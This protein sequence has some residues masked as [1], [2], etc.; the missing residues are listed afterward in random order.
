[1]KR[2]GIGNDM[3]GSGSLRSSKKRKKPN[4]PKAKRNPPP[5]LPSEEE[6]ETD[7]NSEPDKAQ[8]AHPQTTL[9]K[10]T[11]PEIDD[12][13]DVKETVNNAMDYADTWGNL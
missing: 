6:M 3:P 2:F 4:T 7:S 9:E 1:M 5:A 11:R 10:P 8:H 12:K 13:G